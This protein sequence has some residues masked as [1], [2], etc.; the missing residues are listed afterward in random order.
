VK[1]TGG[2]HGR[3]ALVSVP[4]MDG[5]RRGTGCEVRDGSSNSGSGVESDLGVEVA[6][7]ALTGE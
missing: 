3:V 2:W 4:S 5:R 1:T 7:A 6:D